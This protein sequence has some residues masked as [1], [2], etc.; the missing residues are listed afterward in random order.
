MC[1]VLICMISF[2]VVLAMPAWAWEFN[3]DGNTEGWVQSRSLID[4]NEGSLQVTVMD[5]VNQAR[6]I[7]PT[8]S[9]RPP[10]LRPLPG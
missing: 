10:T 4:A 7:S 9:S 5:A 1:R 3:G 8:V 2:V 6:I